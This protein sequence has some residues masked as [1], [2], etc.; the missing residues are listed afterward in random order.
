MA[1]SP[2]YL[3]VEYFL[4]KM[5]NSDFR[6]IGRLDNL[7]GYAF[8]DDVLKGNFS[9]DAD[10]IDLNEL[11]ASESDENDQEPEVSDTASVM[12][13]IRIPENLDI[14]FAGVV[15]QLIYDNLL[16]HDAVGRMTLKEGVASMEQ[17]DMRLLGGRVRMAGSYDSKPEKPAVN[18]DFD[19]RN[20]DIRESYQKFFTI[21]QLAPIMKNSSGLFNTK[22]SFK[23]LLNE[24]MTPDLST[25]FAS[26]TLEAKNLSSSPAVLQ[27][28]SGLLG[29]P[30]MSIL[31]L[32]DVKLRYSVADGRVK[33][34]PFTLTSGSLRSEVSGSMGLDKSL[35]Y[36][37]D[38]SLPLKDIG[39]AKLL[40]Q[41]GSDPNQRV[42]VKV[43]IGGT[44][45]EPSVST[46]LKDIGGSLKEQVV[47]EV[48]EKIDDVVDD[49]KEQAKEKAAQL[50]AD[51]EKKGDQLIA[52][53]QKQADLIV[54]EA[55]KQAALIREEANTQAR[56]IED[57]AKGNFLAEKGAKVAADKVRSEADK[58]AS[59][60]VN[61]AR[62]K[63]NN[64]VDE[65]RNQK[66]KLVEEARSKA[67]VQ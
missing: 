4:A 53:A 42:D 20:F 33:T 40:N 24:D 21:R 61:E 43:F 51:A 59:Q 54:A 3:D 35:D 62:K 18:F 67:D 50:I 57:E 41:L 23:T 27:K 46:S 13:V 17:L 34:E 48:K 16:I 49:A 10:K 37:M 15:R 65:A 36:T 52:E 55:E 22:L 14:K 11:S 2:E 25:T 30:K 60:L 1:V 58:K 44:A 47:K 5:G 31:R 39:A 66:V 8:N 26:G 28:L 63:A 56:K 12:G 19:L 45:T 29:N 38:L 6:L 7:L 32:D 64:L 9:V